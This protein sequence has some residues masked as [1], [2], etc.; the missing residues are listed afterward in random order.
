M[1]DNDEQI[2]V[3][4][5]MT[6][7]PNNALLKQKLVKAIEMAQNSFENFKEK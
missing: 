5:Y 2:K 6:K 1:L 7:L 4:E 3:A